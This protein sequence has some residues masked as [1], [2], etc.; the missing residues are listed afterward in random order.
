MI[1]AQ[2]KPTLL[3][4]LA[5]GAR[6]SCPACGEGHVFDGY[7]KL[8]PACLACGED[9]RHIHADDAPPWLTIVVVGHIM[10]SLIMSLEM[11]FKIPVLWEASAA[12]V[13]AVVLTA[14]LLPVCKGVVVAVLWNVTEKSAG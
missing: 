10:I 4:L 12:V 14:L 7:L 1:K 6:Q 13:L 5:R 2:T 8:V 3:T 11:N 9:L